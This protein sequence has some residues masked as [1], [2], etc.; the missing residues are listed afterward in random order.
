MKTFFKITLLS[1][2]TILFLECSPKLNYLGE[3]YNPT[4]KVLIFYD[5][6]DINKNYKVIGLLNFKETPIFFESK[7]DSAI[8][9]MKNKAKEV[10]ADAI[11]VTKYSQE[12]SSELSE[13]ILSKKVVSKNSENILIEAKFLK[14]K[15]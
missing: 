5:V 12:I 2:F 4:D 6:Q 14:F 3:Y 10:G 1:F 13:D 7:D 11:L 8:T 15:N 9:L